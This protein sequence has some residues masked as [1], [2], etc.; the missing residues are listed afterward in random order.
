[1]SCAAMAR[2]CSLRTAAQLRIMR[3]DEPLQ[4]ARY[5][6]LSAALLPSQ[7]KHREVAEGVVVGAEREQQPCRDE[8]PLCVRHVD[9]GPQFVQGAAAF[10]HR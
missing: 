1:M 4:N 8:W 9:E 2:S 5:R 10:G 6:A 3:V 7:D